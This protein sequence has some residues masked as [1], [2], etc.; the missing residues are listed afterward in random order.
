MIPIFVTFMLVAAHMALADTNMLQDFC[1]A[2]LSNGITTLS[3]TFLFCWHLHLPAIKLQTQLW[4]F[5]T[6][7][8]K[9]HLLLLTF[10][11]F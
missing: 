5:K 7:K 8:T 1:V 6:T 10:I 3:I 2:D 11:M 9:F 4:C